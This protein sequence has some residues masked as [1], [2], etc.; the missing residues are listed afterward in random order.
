MT[1]RSPDREARYAGL[2]ARA[3]IDDEAS[4]APSSLGDRAADVAAIERALRARGRRHVRPWLAGVGSA[5][6]A[7]VLVAVAWPAPRPAPPAAVE[8]HAMQAAPTAALPPAPAASIVALDGAG[9]TVEVAGREAPAAVRDEIAAGTRLRVSPAGELTL[10]LATGT[11]LRAAGGSS[12]RV[13]ELGSMQR[14]ELESGALAAEVAKLGAGRRFVIATPDAEIEVKG[15]RF[16]VAVG[17]DPSLCEPRVRTRV[18]VAEGVV[19]VRHGSGEVRLAAGDRWP[20]CGSPR[21]ATV[22]APAAREIA[23]ARASATAAY[24]AEARTDRAPPPGEVPRAAAEM[25]RTSNLAEQ[26]DLFAAALSAGRRGDAEEALHWLEQLIAR[27]PH[28]QLIDS[29]RAERGRLIGAI[30]GR[31]SGE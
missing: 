1:M 5:A 2:A 17:A 27:Y 11:R 20:E 21:P 4:S 12:A 7:A 14:F 9:S 30:A 29:A 24:R 18:A 23:S 15:T 8:R 31:R 3:L 13:V 28:G 6:A 25:S 26:N 19:V 22:S 16:E 10:A